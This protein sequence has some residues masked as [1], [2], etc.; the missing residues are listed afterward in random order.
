MRT[1][2]FFWA[3]NREG[4]GEIELQEL[5]DGYWCSNEREFM[6]TRTYCSRLWSVHRSLIKEPRGHRRWEAS[7]PSRISILRKRHSLSLT[8]LPS[9]PTNIVIF[10]QGESLRLSLN[11]LRD[12]LKEYSPLMSGSIER[13]V[14]TI[15]NYGSAFAEVSPPIWELANFDTF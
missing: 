2:H 12:L 14:G 7:L 15:I 9:R 10:S 3:K 5:F 11:K 8:H 1:G 6:V 4:S 13:A